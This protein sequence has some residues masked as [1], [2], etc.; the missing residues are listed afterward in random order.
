MNCMDIQGRDET[1]NGVYTVYVASRSIQVY[2]DMETDGGGWTVIQRRVD[3]SQ[4]FSLGWDDYAAGF[5]SAAGEF[6]IG[7]R[8]L[9][10]LTSTP[11]AVSLRLDMADDKE[12]KRYAQY[13]Y[14]QVGSEAEKFKLII[15]SWVLTHLGDTMTTVHNG[16]MFSTID[17]D[18]DITPGNCA[19]LYKGGWW[20]AKCHAANPN[21][22]YLNG[23]HTTYADGINWK[24]WRGYRYSLPFFEMKIR[25]HF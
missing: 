1:Q 10:L 5:G 18:N 20:Y 2:C 23:A 17:Q 19:A 6:W 21:G 9:H 12:Q 16:M 22:L 13:D 4:N 25:P 15:N 11:R 14:F 8:N 7:N 3:G 24:T